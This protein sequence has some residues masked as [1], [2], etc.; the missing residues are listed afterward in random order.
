MFLMKMI[1]IDDIDLELVKFRNNSIQTLL[2]CI[3]INGFKICSED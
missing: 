1:W 2:V 3:D